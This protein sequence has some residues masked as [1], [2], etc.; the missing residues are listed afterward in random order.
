MRLYITHEFNYLRY[1]LH[2]PLP[3]A[4]YLFSAKIAQQDFAAKMHGGGGGGGG[5]MREGVGRRVCV[6]GKL[7]YCKN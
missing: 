3:K 7:Q 5:L 4:Y 2:L 6:C 1:T